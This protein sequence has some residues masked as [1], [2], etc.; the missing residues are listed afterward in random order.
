MKPIRLGVSPTG[1][2]EVLAVQANDVTGGIEA[3]SVHEGRA[4]AVHVDR[5]AERL[6]ALDLLR[7]ES[8]RCDDPDVP[9]AGFVEG[10]TQELDETWRDAADIGAACDTFPLL[11]LANDRQVHP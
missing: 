8:A 1:L 2:R 3:A 4:D 10:R 7:V 6:E 5:H 9:V 11:Q